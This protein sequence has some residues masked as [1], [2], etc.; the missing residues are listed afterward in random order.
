MKEGETGLHTF[1]RVAYNSEITPFWRNLQELRTLFRPNR[2]SLIFS[3]ILADNLQTIL[4]YLHT[5]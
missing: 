3:A 5:S 1:S 2:K 4:P